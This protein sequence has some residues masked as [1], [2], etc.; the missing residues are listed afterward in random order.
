M[1]FRSEESG[2]GAAWMLDKVVVRNLETGEDTFFL[3]GRW[4]A[5]DEGDGQL[6]RELAASS[7]DGTT[8]APMIS[9]KI[10]TY[11]GDR[12]GAGTDANVFCTLYGKSG[13]SGKVTLVPPS[14]KIDP[15]ERS[16]VG[17]FG[18]D[19]IDLGDL[20]R[21]E[22]GHDG[23]GFMSGWYLDKV[24][25]TAGDGRKWVFGCD[26]WLAKSEGD[27]AIVRDL[28]PS[29]E[30]FA[31]TPQSTFK[32]AIHTADVRFAGTSADVTLQLYGTTGKSDEVTLT[33]GGRDTFDRAAIDQ[34]ELTCDDI[35]EPTKLRIGHNNKGWGAGWLLNG[36]VVTSQRH[37]GKKIGRAHV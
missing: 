29:P 37:K 21:V 7:A 4:F 9:Y 34:F 32:I 3:C 26:K 15:F 12:R 2:L 13:D 30:D 16:R 20:T 11:T 23:A 27:G 6:T 24:V 19:C 33:N 35:G 14:S 8:Y 10:E 1:L 5:S 18:V 17:K 25:V 28:A 22:I 36:V 31:V